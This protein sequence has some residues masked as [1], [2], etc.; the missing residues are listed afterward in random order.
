M[1]TKNI[2]HIIVNVHRECTFTHGA[3]Y[4]SQLIVEDKMKSAKKILIT[5]LVLLFAAG[6]VFAE[7]NQ[8]KGGK[9]GVTKGMTRKIVMGH[10][11]I[12]AESV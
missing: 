2:T 4:L 7:G 11:Q 5:E 6:S 9:D 10:S 1:T 3:I 12:G 8:D